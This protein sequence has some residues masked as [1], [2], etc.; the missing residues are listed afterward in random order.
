MPC[1]TAIWERLRAANFHGSVAAPWQPPSQHWSTWRSVAKKGHQFE[2]WGSLFQS[3]KLLGVCKNNQG[4]FPCPPT[5]GEG[6]YWYRKPTG[7]SPFLQVAATHQEQA[8]RRGW[9][10]EGFGPVSSLSLEKRRWSRGVVV[11]HVSGEWTGL[12]LLILPV[13]ELGGAS[14]ETCGDKLEDEAPGGVPRTPAAAC[15]SGIKSG[16]VHSLCC[17]QWHPVY[18]DGDGLGKLE[19]YHRCL[20]YT[21][22]IEFWLLFET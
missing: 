10:L 11:S 5:G 2:R 6:L 13:K 15:F 19:Q 17:V 21:L 20:S 14:N 7:L 16:D 22:E 9:D 3:E 4:K 18:W 1:P 8:Q 12:W